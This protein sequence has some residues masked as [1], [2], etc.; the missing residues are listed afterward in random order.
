MG[1]EIYGKK[2]IYEKYVCD[3]AATGV[4][5]GAGR[6]SAHNRAGPTRAESP[7]TTLTTT[8]IIIH[9]STVN[10]VDFTVTI[11]VRKF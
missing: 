2:Y 9:V 5:G 10:Y 6:P 4:G 7:A 3:C 1:L 8:T 11:N